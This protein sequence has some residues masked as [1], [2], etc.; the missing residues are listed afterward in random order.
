MIYKITYGFRTAVG[1]VC[2]NTS[3][4][5]DANSAKDALENWTKHTTKFVLYNLTHIEVLEIQY[6]SHGHRNGKFELTQEFTRSDYAT[7]IESYK[8]VL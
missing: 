6:D 3:L 1:N 7:F 2:Y 4:G 8:T 5:V